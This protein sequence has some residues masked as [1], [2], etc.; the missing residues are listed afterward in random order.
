MEEHWNHHNRGFLRN[1]H[2]I[3]TVRMEEQHQWRNNLGFHSTPQTFVGMRNVN[4]SSS[5]KIRRTWEGCIRYTSNQFFSTVTAPI[6]EEET[7]ESPSISPTTKRNRTKLRSSEK[8]NPH[9][10]GR[11]IIIRHG[12]SIWNVTDPD[13]GLTA[14]FTGWAD[15]GLTEKG[16][17]QAKAAGKA[18]IN[19][20]RD[21]NGNP[22]SIDCTFSSLLSQSQDTMDFVLDELGLTVPTQS[23][24]RKDREYKVP[25]IASW[26][27]NERHYGG[28]VG[29]SKDGAERLYSYEDLSKWRNS[30]STRP[31]H[32]TSRRRRQWLTLD[33]CQMVTRAKFPLSN[34]NF[35]NSSFEKDHVYNIIEKD[36]VPSSQTQMPLSES[37]SDTYNQ[38]IPFWTQAI[39][40]RIRQGQNVLIVKHN[41][42]DFTHD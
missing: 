8:L 7:L 6:I 16:K 35:P 28:L 23:Q 42:C 17:D 32:M 9:N 39:T 31:P 41:S 18:L 26:R 29:L 19:N 11:V 14:R 5:I 20:F 24:S 37:M 15:I 40:P 25:W 13:L 33:H 38:V 22:H 1:V 34:L 12:Q 3:H 36:L 2:T 30:W 10:V 27:L 21:A 4:I